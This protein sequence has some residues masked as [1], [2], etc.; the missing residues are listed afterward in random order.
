MC[1]PYAN[2]KNFK[3][4]Q[5]AEDCEKTGTMHVYV[6]PTVEWMDYAMEAKARND[7]FLKILFLSNLYTQ[8][9]A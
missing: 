8:H 5:N 6:T 1:Q 2:Q 7:S 9:G 3:T 4:P